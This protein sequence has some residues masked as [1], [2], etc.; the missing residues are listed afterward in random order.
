[1]GL[2]YRIREDINR[3]EKEGEKL[4]AEYL[5]KVVVGPLVLYPAGLAKFLRKFS[6]YLRYNPEEEIAVLTGNN[7]GE[8]V[9]ILE[10][11]DCDHS[12]AAKIANLLELGETEDSCLWKRWVPVLKLGNNRSNGFDSLRTECLKLG[13]P[14]RIEKSNHLFL[15]DEEKKYEETEGWTLEQMLEVVRETSRAMHG[16]RNAA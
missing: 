8:M 10:V 15:R 6:Y 1:V 12:A 7:G 13:V 3:S 2:T 5:K 16:K 14:F 4:K 11:R 9:G